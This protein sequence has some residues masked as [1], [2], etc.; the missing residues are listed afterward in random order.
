[1]P[2]SALV[3]YGGVYPVGLFLSLGALAINVI[4]TLWKL[5]A[6]K[7]GLGVWGFILIF[8]L[9]IVILPFWNYPAHGVFSVFGLWTLDLNHYVFCLLILYCLL[10]QRN[11]KR[12]Y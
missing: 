5:I 8:M 1:M 12:P 3:K 2:D 4:I 7:A 9:F 10:W 11:L 6:K